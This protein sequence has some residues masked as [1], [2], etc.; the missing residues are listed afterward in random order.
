MHTI[1]LTQSVYHHRPSHTISTAASRTD[2]I[3]NRNHQVLLMRINA[4]DCIS[5]FYHSYPIQ[6]LKGR[7]SICHLFTGI[8]DDAC[9]A[10]S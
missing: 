5:H 6:F 4:S 3:Q 10:D 9:V 8:V 7:Q 2:H 1:P